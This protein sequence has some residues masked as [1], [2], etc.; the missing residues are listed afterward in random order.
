MREGESE[1]T[2]S[3][4]CHKC[5]GKKSICLGEFNKRH[6][7]FDHKKCPRCL[8]TGVE[9]SGWR[10]PEELPT[11]AGYYMVIWD[12]KMCDITYILVRTMRKKIIA[13]RELPPLPEWI[14]DKT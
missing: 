6:S 2:M 1:E 10:K 9:P 8:G 14:G 5:E 12:N 3:E 7:P 11:K 4:P 13:W